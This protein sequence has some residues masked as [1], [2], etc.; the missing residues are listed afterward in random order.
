MWGF[1]LALLI[2]CFL[3][4][5]KGVNEGGILLRVYILSVLTETPFMLRF[6]KHKYMERYHER[7]I[8]KHMLNVKG[9]IYFINTHIWFY[10][11]WYY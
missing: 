2:I 4:P 9:E 5:R 1:K 8:I 10:I 7:P 3:L 6:H 11:L